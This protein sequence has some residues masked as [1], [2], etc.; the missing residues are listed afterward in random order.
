M[1]TSPLELALCQ[2]HSTCQTFQ[3]HPKRLV[4]Q[5]LGLFAQFWLTQ[6]SKWLKQNISLPRVFSSNHATKKPAPE[7]PTAGT[8]VDV[9]FRISFVV[10]RLAVFR[11]SDNPEDDMS[12]G[13]Y[14]VFQL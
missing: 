8:G 5:L 2:Q 11:T 6:S 9:L 7:Y 12:S 13:G 3:S 14:V 4:D 1:R 10:Q